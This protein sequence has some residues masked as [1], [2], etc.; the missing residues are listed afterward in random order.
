M[1]WLFVGCSLSFFGAFIFYIFLISH[2]SV[3]SNIFLIFYFFNSFCMTFLFLLFCV[4][5][6]PFLYFTK[7]VTSFISPCIV[8][9]IHF[10]NRL[11]EHIWFAC[12]ISPLLQ[13][14]MIHYMFI[15]T[16]VIDWIKI[17]IIITSSWIYLEIYICKYLLTLY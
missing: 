15:E 5:T 17:I 11:T 10:R 1:C 2:I 3:L 16:T 12:Y 4:T 8:Q 7:E 13:W 6:P 14:H 9:P